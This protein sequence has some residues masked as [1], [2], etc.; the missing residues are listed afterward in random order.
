[1]TNPPQDDLE[2]VEELFDRAFNEASGDAIKDLATLARRAV[3]ERDKWFSAHDTM[4]RECNRL[5][6]ERDKAVAGLRGAREALRN[7]ELELCALL[8]VPSQPDWMP[9]LGA[10]NPADADCLDNALRFARA[11]LRQAET[12]GDDGK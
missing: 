4:L 7:V 5:I 9:A 8:P 1:M 11:A 3:E 10:S 6:A 12:G 2:R